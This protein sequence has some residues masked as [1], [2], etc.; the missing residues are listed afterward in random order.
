MGCDFTPQIHR[1]ILAAQDLLIDQNYSAA[2]KK[3]NKILA[4]SND[5]N[6]RSKVIF[7]LAEIYLL[8]YDNARKSLTLLNKIKTES[9]NLEAIIKAEEKIANINFSVLHDYKTALKNYL[10]LISFKPY[11]KNHKFYILRYAKSALLAGNYQI[12]IEMFKKMIKE[13]QF[14]EIAYFYLGQSYF[15]KQEWKKAIKNLKKYLSFNNLE[16][17]IKAQLLLANSYE[18]IEELKK[19]YDIYYGLL[20]DYPNPEVIRNKLNSIYTRQISSKR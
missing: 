12:A 13:K 16:N 18:N 8:H 19:A 17:R 20:A 1:D 15:Y 7:Q 3:Y 6:I 10:N 5:E 9:Q 2:I 4:T 14:G 11:L